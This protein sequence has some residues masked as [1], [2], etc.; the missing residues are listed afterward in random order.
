MKT[1]RSGSRSIWPSNQACRCAS[2]CARCC[3]AA[4]AVFFERDALFRVEAPD[5]RQGHGDAALASQS[6]RD[7][8][9]GDVPP[10]LD[11]AEQK[12]RMLGQFGALPRLAPARLGSLSAM[13]VPRLGPADRGGR[14]QGEPP[15]GGSRRGSGGDGIEEAAPQVLAR[16][17]HLPLRLHASN[18]DNAPAA[19]TIHLTSKMLYLDVLER[20]PSAMAGS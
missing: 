12:C 10:L 14:R 20:K 7:L 13:R 8:V 17:S 4:C 11:Q 19:A 6:R 5:G 9:Q 2:T 1:R 16:A 15:S 18:Q 3:S